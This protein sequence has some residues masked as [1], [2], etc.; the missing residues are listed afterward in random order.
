MTVSAPTAKV[1][2]PF[3][4]TNALQLGERKKNMNIQIDSVQYFT[5]RRNV[6]R[7]QFRLVPARKVNASQWQ[8]KNVL[9]IYGTTK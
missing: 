2:Y 6:L 4:Q 1:G 9:R 7:L 5:S 3:S 8:M